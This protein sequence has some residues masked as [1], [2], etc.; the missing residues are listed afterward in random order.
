MIENI[1][2]LYTLFEPPGTWIC[3]QLWILEHVVIYII[4]HIKLN[5]LVL[6]SIFVISNCKLVANY[7]CIIS[8]R[9]FTAAFSQSY[10]VQNMIMIM[11]TGWVVI[12]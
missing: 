9:C 6:I 1:N 3:S 7:L 10:V 4:L 2:G 8:Y 5:N 11:I 12:T